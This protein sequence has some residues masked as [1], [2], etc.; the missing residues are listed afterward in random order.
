MQDGYIGKIAPGETETL[1][2][3]TMSDIANI[4][5]LEIVKK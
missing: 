2:V 1:N 3:S 4:Y 5:N